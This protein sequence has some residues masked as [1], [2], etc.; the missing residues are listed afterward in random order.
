MITRTASYV[1]VL[2]TRAWYRVQK[3][4]WLFMETLLRLMFYLQD[5]T[6]RS[7]LFPN[8]DPQHIMTGHRAAVNALSISH[9]HI[10][11]ASG[12]R[13][14]RLW[15]ADTGALLRT[16]ENHHSR[17]YVSSPIRCPI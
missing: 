11:S 1:F 2:M 16:F 9:T 12:D 13:S 15:D 3:V 5:R 6:V 4:S 8:L 7:Y 14:L 10:V 17:G